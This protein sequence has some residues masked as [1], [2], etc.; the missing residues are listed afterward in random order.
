MY[1]ENGQECLQAPKGSSTPPS[2]IA[3]SSPPLPWLAFFF[4][5]MKGKGKERETSTRL[6]CL[7]KGGVW[8]CASE[9]SGGAFLSVITCGEDVHRGSVHAW[10]SRCLLFFP[11]DEVGGFLTSAGRFAFFFCFTFSETRRLLPF[12]LL[13]SL[14]LLMRSFDAPTPHPTACVA[15]STSTF[16]L[17]L[18]SS[19]S[20]SL[21]VRKEEKGNKINC[22]RAAF[23]SFGGL[24]STDAPTCFP[25]I[26]PLLRVTISL[27]PFFRR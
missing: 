25:F 22:H 20:H 2:G 8:V 4:P 27:S 13:W 24:S 15:T 9:N 26:P 18:R 3:N 21:L 11:G 16:V 1:I 14:L 17:S 12:F 23:V 7:L 6:L 19:T 5:A 10:Q